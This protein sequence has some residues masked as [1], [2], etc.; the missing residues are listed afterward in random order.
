MKRDNMSNQ[1]LEDHKI[2]RQLIREL[3]TVIDVESALDNFG[4]AVDRH[5][6]FEVRMV[7]E[8]SKYSQREIVSGDRSILTY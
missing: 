1:V 8:N 4:K 5:I 3:E 7:R 2:I 6:R